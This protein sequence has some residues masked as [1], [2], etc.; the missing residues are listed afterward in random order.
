M[1][2]VS[3]TLLLFFLNCFILSVSCA[4][5]RDLSSD[6]PTKVLANNTEALEDTRSLQQKE[7]ELKEVQ[8]PRET[9]YSYYYVARWLWHIPL[10]FLLWFTIYVAANVFRSMYGHTVSISDRRN[11]YY[12]ILLLKIFA[13]VIEPD[14]HDLNLRTDF[15]LQRIPF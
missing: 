12:K 13:F 7:L 15:D 3:R 4:K 5:L 9:T 2:S 6:L 11:F 10:W 1:F 8:L 14:R